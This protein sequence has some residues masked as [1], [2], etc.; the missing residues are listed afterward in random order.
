MSSLLF[1][2][3]LFFF[4]CRKMHLTNIHSRY[5]IHSDVFAFGY[6]GKYCL[7]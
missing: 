1:L 4:R 6:H 3:L 7:Y 5:V 2:I